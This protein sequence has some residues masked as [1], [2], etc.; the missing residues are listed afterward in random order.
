MWGKSELRL[1]D[2]QTTVVLPPGVN[3]GSERIIKQSFRPLCV[4]LCVS[5]IQLQHGV[6]SGHRGGGPILC[7]RSA[8]NAAPQSGRPPVWNIL[9]DC[10]PLGRAVRSRAN[11]GKFA[12]HD[13]A[14]CADGARGQPPNF[15]PPRRTKNSRTASPW[16]Q[17]GELKRT[18]VNSTDP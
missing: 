7:A 18:G 15:V 13:C 9:S 17:S 12:A 2:C 5:A 10:A 8:Q 14:P 3:K 11:L 1:V 6:R 16:T 4:P